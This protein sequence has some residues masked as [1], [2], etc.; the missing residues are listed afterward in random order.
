MIKPSFPLGGVFPSE[1]F[2]FSSEEDVSFIINFIAEKEMVVAKNL[3]GEVDHSDETIG[4]FAFGVDVAAGEGGGVIVV[5]GD[6][7]SAVDVR[8]VAD[9]AESEPPAEIAEIMC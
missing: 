5:R 4:E 3:T 2:V 1:C 6:F 9:M 7:D 8:F